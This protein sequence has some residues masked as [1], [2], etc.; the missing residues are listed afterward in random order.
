M[1]FRP[2]SAELKQKNYHNSPN[3]QV[4]ETAPFNYLFKI[5]KSVLYLL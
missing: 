2:P 3:M 1:S 5:I 4:H